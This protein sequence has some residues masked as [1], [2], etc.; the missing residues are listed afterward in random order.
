MTVFSQAVRFALVGVG[1]TL[2][3]VLVAVWLIDACGQPLVVANGAAFVVATLAS[4]TMNTLWSFGRKLEVI[5]LARF[6]SVSFVGFL[7]TLGI[8]ALTE[9]MD[10]PYPVGIALVVLLVP[11]ISFMLHRIWTYRCL[12][13]SPSSISN[14]NGVA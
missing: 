13:A 2:I 1:V 7:A 14:G 8:S 11:G 5:S 3:H 4:Y 12:D 10:L 6:I 9:S